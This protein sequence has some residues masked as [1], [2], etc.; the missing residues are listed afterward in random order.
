MSNYRKIEIWG[1]RFFIIKETEFEILVAAR[2]SLIPIGVERHRTIAWAMADDA[3]SPPV[4]RVIV[5][6]IRGAD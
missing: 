5:E 6:T 2:M 1:V 4:M 3:V